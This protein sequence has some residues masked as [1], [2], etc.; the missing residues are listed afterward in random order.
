MSAFKMTSLFYAAMAG[1]PV[2]LWL[3]AVTSPLQ[4][5]QLLREV[6]ATL[7]GIGMLVFGIIGLREVFMHG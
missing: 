4:Q 6:L 5:L 2:L 3:I 1:V 7:A